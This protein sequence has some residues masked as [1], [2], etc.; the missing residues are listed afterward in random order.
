MPP[1]SFAGIVT[2]VGFMNKTATVTVSRWVFDKRTGK[3]FARSKKFLVHDEQN[4][5]L[6]EDSVVIKNCPPISARKR[7]TLDSIVSSPERERALAHSAAA[8]AAAGTP[9]PTS[10]EPASA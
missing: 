6:R 9:P 7:F 2:K 3:R 4:Q 10:A 5:L 1:M 8:A